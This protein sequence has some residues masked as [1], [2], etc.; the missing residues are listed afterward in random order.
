MTMTLSKAEL[1]LYIIT[2]RIS[3]KFCFGRSWLGTPAHVLNE[4][5]ALMRILDKKLNWSERSMSFFDSQ[6]DWEES[7]Q[8][9]DFWNSEF[10]G[11]RS[12]K[13]ELSLIARA[14]LELWVRQL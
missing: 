14:Q 4:R 1:D 7:I 12:G 3:E 2:G 6:I 9:I 13:K 8:G 11:F 5:K 10:I